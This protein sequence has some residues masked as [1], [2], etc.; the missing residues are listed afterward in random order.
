MSTAG[1]LLLCFG[2]AA[3]PAAVAVPPY[4]PKRGD[5]WTYR[6]TV[7]ETDRTQRRHD[8]EV[9]ALVLDRT[10]RYADVA[11]LTLLRRRDDIVSAAVPAVTG[12]SRD[13]R[14]LPPA[15]RLDL[16]RLSPDGTARLLA[17][18]AKLPLAL[19]DRTPTT[20]GPYVSDFLQSDFGLFF[21]RPTGVLA[22]G[23]TW[24]CPDSAGSRVGQRW[25]A[26]GEDFVAGERCLPVT[27]VPPDGVAS[28]SSCAATVWL[29][30]LDGSVRRVRVSGDLRHGRP[31]GV[32]RNPCS[33]EVG[34]ELYDRAH[35]LGREFDRCRRDIDVAYAFGAD[36][37]GLLPNAAK[38]GAKPFEMRVARLDDYLRE[39]PDDSP[40]REAVRAVRR[41]L[42]AARKGEAVPAA[43]AVEPTATASPAVPPGGRKAGPR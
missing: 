7:V 40:Y 1:F 32:P 13:A 21:P 24:P 2:P 35:V 17:P 38:L 39:T 3:P 30:T 15:V 4:Q 27:L 34:Y 43:V 28:A 20:A 33:T 9:R 11:V 23:R 6:G 41:R 29:S 26:G 16:V 25:A 8:L 42:D 22:S 10:G 19:N 37:G 12:Q 31:D 14:S 5:E 18:P 36:L